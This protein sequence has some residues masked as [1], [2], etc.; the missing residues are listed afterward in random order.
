MLSIPV[1]G[2]EG[3]IQHLRKF[4][5]S[6][7][8][9]SFHKKRRN[10]DPSTDADNDQDNKLDNVMNDITILITLFARVIHEISALSRFL[11]KGQS[12][13]DPLSM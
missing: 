4:L 5:L 10:K 8:K 12:F 6:L 3:E 7:Q 2:D 1:H 9:K 11:K 13:V